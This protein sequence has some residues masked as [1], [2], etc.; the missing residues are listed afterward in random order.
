MWISPLHPLPRAPRSPGAKTSLRLAVQAVS[1]PRRRF[2][3]IGLT[4]AVFALLFAIVAFRRARRRRFESVFRST[5]R[6]AP[7]DEGSARGEARATWG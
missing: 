2:I 1:P 6:G 5:A 4:L 3:E 7:E